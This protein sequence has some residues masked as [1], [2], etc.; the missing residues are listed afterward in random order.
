VRAGLARHN[1]TETGFPGITA[2][3]FFD[4]QQHT[5]RNIIVEQVFDSELRP[6]F[7][8]LR[9]V[10]DNFTHDKEHKI[11][12]VD[13][14]SYFKQMVAYIGMDFYRLEEV[15]EQKDRIDITAFMWLKWHGDPSLDSVT[16]QNAVGAVEVTKL[17]NGTFAEEVH[18]LPKRR[19]TKN[20]Q[21]EPP[22]MYAAYKVKLPVQYQFQLAQ[23][24]FDTQ[25]F[26]ITIGDANRDF[27]SLAFVV[28]SDY[29]NDKKL[30]SPGWEQIGR[31]DYA[32]Y[33]Y[34]ESTFGSYPWAERNSH[35]RV[36]SAS[37]EV[38]VKIERVVFGYL[39]SLFVPLL[40]CLFLC[41]LTFSTRI[42]DVSSRLAVL[43]GAFFVAM[44]SHMS[45]RTTLGVSYLVAADV[46]YFITY[47][48]ILAGIL[49]VN[50]IEKRR[51]KD[52]DNAV[53]V[54]HYV[55][56]LLVGFSMFAFIG[57]AAKL[58]FSRASAL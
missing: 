31:Q 53:R 54:Q 34:Q 25:T 18:A 58:M 41:F 45:L 9:F 49:A 50:F 15:A 51:Q 29:I 39:F 4:E 57:L 26:P 27:T 14:Y 10:P 38:L 43:T 44:L 2:R 6:S 40:A 3:V 24:P 20:A 55:R 33:F 36:Y 19:F 48:S 17:R 5:I 52:V 32:A 30:M 11:I 23:F 1:S 8:Q 12:D 16:L 56:L 35:Q 42:D 7:R 21:P 13:G 47:G 22:V 37:Y 46:F 28:E